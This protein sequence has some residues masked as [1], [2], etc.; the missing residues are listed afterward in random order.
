MQFKDGKGWKQLGL[1][2]K[3][4]YDIKLGGELSPGKTLC[5]RAER[6]GGSAFEFEVVARLDTPTEVERY[7]AGGVLSASLKEILERSGAR[8]LGSAG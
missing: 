1:N 4:K 8:A 2:G 3:E 5:V 7:R 6:D